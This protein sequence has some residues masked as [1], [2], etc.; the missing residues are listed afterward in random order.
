MKCNFILLFTVI[1]LYSF[2]SCQQPVQEIM[3]DQ[4]AKALMD[5]YMETMNKADLDLVDEIISPDFVLRTP[6]LPEPLV[7]IENYKNLVTNTSNTFSDFNANIDEIN[8]KGDKVWCRFSMEGVNTGL[9]G[10]LPA[11]EKSFHITG[12]AITHIV[13]GKIVADET[14]WDVLGFYQQ[15]GFTL[16]PPQEQSEQ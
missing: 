5:S 9:L 7:G 15:L 4:E 16:V 12:L 8:V 10:E 11:T 3:S 6:F 1:L 2:F 14:F 13:D